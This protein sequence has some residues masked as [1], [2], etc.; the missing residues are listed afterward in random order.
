[1]LVEDGGLRR[2]I[3]GGVD[4]EGRGRGGERRVKVKD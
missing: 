4:G 3:E 2:F 1:M